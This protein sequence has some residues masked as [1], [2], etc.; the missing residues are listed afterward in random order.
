MKRL[1]FGI[2][3]T[4]VLAQPQIC[5]AYFS[6]FTTLPGNTLGFGDWTP[7]KTI[8]IVTQNGK[9]SQ[10]QELVTNGNFL[11]EF[12]GWQAAGYVKITERVV[13]LGDSQDPSFNISS[14]TQVIPN[15]SPTLTF[16]Y[17]LTG[18][19]EQ[20]SLVPVFTVSINDQPVYQTATRTENNVTIPIN[21]SAFSEPSLN[22]VFALEQDPNLAE[23]P[24]ILELH[25]VTTTTIAANPSAQFSFFSEDR[26]S[27][28]TYYH[29]ANSAQI[30]F[31][32]LFNLSP[33][34][35]DTLFT[36]W[37]EDLSHNIEEAHRFPLL[38]HEYLGEFGV[39]TTTREP[40]GEAVIAFAVPE[41][42]CC[43]QMIDVRISD[44][45]ITNDTN[46]DSLPTA[47]I[48]QES[49]H[50]PQQQGTER[51]F[52]DHLDETK[53]YFIAIRIIDNYGNI[54]KPTIGVL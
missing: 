40:N 34:P 7:P 6:N 18:G 23:S 54:S 35:E 21:L 27:T 38:F 41:S 15:T 12:Q 44:T 43:I 26:H 32:H 52:I 49:L 9:Q 4:A 1:I 30:A 39:V 36:F 22:I 46:L 10:V 25:V 3:F 8:A 16:T 14:I 29:L 37:S 50:A 5:F 24:H 11:D 28:A 31:T 45:P 19:D 33:G 51:L 20:E 48:T 17:R 13:V 53:S 2:L 47:E 42:S